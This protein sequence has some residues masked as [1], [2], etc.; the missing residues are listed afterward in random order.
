MMP[1][2]NPSG[3]LTLVEHWT[4]THCAIRRGDIVVAQSPAQPN[5]TVVK[6]V[7]GLPGDNICPDP[8]AAEAGA[9][10]PLFKVP[11]GHYWLQGDNFRN[12]TDSRSYGPVPFGLIRGKV[13]S[14]VLPLDEA[15]WI[16][17][18]VETV[19]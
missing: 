5:K 7:V 12:S 10:M 1:T 14:R 2:F 3:D 6:R 11:P 15:K 13:V 19:D 16:A 9:A 18:G 8:S 17:D 4:P